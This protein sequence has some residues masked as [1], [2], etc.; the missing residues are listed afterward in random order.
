MLRKELGS[1]RKSPEE[2]LRARYGRLEGSVYNDRTYYLL[3]LFGKP[4]AHG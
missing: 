4:K 3:S 2:D 1:P